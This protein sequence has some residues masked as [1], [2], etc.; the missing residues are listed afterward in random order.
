MEQKTKTGPLQRIFTSSP[1]A[2]IL[3]FLITAQESDYSKNDISKYSGVSFRHTL[4]VLPN[5]EQQ[6]L[7]KHTR[8]V[9]LAHMYKYNTNN[10]TA[11]ILEKFTNHQACDRLQKIVDE[12]EKREKENPTPIIE[13]EAGQTCLMHDCTHN[14]N[15]TCTT[16][17]KMKGDIC[18]TYQETQN[19]NNNQTTKQA[20]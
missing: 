13:Q 11:M 14:T 17:P 19:P 20:K 15:K 10:P 2:K 8:K 6:G 3:D 16:R 5:L 1:E 18:Q 7:I 12:E 9:S 4:K